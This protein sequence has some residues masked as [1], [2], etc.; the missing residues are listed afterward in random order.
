MDDAKTGKIA[1]SLI[2]MIYVSQVLRNRSEKLGIKRPTADPH[3]WI[4]AVLQEE[5]L[6]ISEIGRRLQKSKQNMTALVDKLIEEGKVERKPDA[7]DRRVVRIR[8]TAKGSRFMK[9]SRNLI[10]ENVK[11]NLAHLSEDDLR[12]FCT[13]LENLS[14]VAPKIIKRD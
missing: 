6:P 1:D 11:R 2:S 5:S 4:M 14:K 10:K 7:K 3:Y 8:L 12:V 13:S 9:E